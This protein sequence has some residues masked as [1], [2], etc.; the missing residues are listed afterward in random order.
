MILRYK[1]AF[2]FSLDAFI[3][4]IIIFFTLQYLIF[5]SYSPYSYFNSLRQAQY[6]ASD[7]LNSL[8]LLEYEN[9]S[10]NFLSKA[11]R[12]AYGY[13]SFPNELISFS[14]IVIP[15]TYSYAYDFYDFSS[16][17]WIPIYNATAIPA[18][19]ISF[20]K[21]MASSYVLQVSYLDPLI[22]GDSPYC[23]IECKGYDLA[24]GKYSK[25][26]NCTQVPCDIKHGTT[27][28]PG[29]VT[30]GVMRLTVWG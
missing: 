15:P 18:R 22:K 28:D 7:T 16:G 14:N 11:I 21:V 25:P 30:I 24:T 20:Y 23:N 19:N 12:F 29:N 13:G 10:N 26:Q 9:S 2:I 4:S 27:F 1:K 6:L 5:L 17:T 8:Y 3:A